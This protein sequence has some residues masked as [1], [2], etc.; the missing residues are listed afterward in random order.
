M[1]AK[2]V[3]GA[4]TARPDDY[5]IGRVYYFLTNSCTLS[6]GTISSVKI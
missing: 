6:A 1:G 3:I 5:W 4:C 2:K